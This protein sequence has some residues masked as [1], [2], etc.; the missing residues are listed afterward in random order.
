ESRFR[1][2]S[3]RRLPLCCSRG[4]LPPHH[5]PPSVWRN[6]ESYPA[7]RTS[8]PGTPLP[9]QQ[10]KRKPDTD[11]RRRL[12]QFFP[13]AHREQCPASEQKAIE[14]LPRKFQAQ[15][16]LPPFPTREGPNCWLDQAES[17]RSFG[18]RG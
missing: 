10:Q 15:Q 8:F 7:R 1:A 11:L 14:P 4:R 2:G 12:L 9:E 13:N 5:T 16:C 6:P 18:T 3:V 17:E